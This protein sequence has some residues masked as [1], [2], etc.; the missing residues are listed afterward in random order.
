MDFCELE[1]MEGGV[2]NSWKG[3]KYFCGELTRKILKWEDVFE[4]LEPKMGGSCT[5]IWFD[6]KGGLEPYL[7]DYLVQYL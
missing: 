6:E 2:Q 1:K 3:L 4:F 5:K 7:G